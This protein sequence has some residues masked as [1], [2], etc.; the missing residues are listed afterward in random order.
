[1]GFLSKMKR[2]KSDLRNS[3][4][5]QWRISQNQTNIGYEILD[6]IDTFV[7]NKLTDHFAG[8]KDAKLQSEFVLTEI[9]Q[10]N[11]HIIL[12]SILIFPLLG[13]F[14]SRKCSSFFNVNKTF[15]HTLL[16]F[17]LL[18]PKFNLMWVNFAYFHN[19]LDDYKNNEED[20]KNCEISWWRNNSRMSD[21]K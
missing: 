21:Q 5:Q 4:T 6:S 19:V 12:N 18:S 2:I 20:H 15:S 16:V 17:H 7:D 14:H 10:I 13:K 3:M 9:L 1:M 8:A 11:L